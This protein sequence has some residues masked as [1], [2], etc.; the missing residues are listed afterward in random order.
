MSVFAIVATIYV[1]WALLLFTM[2]RRM[3][4]PGWNA[5]LPYITTGDVPDGVESVRLPFS[6]GGGE[7]WFLAAP[8]HGPAPAVVFAH[9]N[10]ELIDNGLR[11]ALSLTGLG[12]SVL[13]VE[14][15]GY[16][17]SE[18]TPSRRSIGEVFLAAYD[19][20][21]AR[22]DVDGERIVGMG[23]SLGTGAITDLARVR[24]LRALVLQSPYVSVAHF[25]RRYLLPGFL[26]RDRFDNLEVLR[27]FDGPVLLI[28]GRRDEVIP[29]SH[30]ERLKR[31]APAVELLSLDCG[32][33]NCPPDWAVYVASLE[34][35]LLRAGVLS[36]GPR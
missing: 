33:N 25:A 9:G 20:L 16:G 10:A 18:G 21:T 22:P 12:M 36:Q 17:Q 4:F 5:A 15:P 31:A 26:A 3:M 7:A 19:W 32:H 34:E 24:P 6:S 2:Q 11:D 29:Y 30:S 27:D 28:H 13:L 14:Y 8:G 23:R 1:G 35:F